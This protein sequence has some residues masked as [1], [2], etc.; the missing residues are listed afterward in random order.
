[1]ARKFFPKW[2]KRLLIIFVILIVIVQIAF[3]FMNFRMSDRKV[4]E[5]FMARSTEV[6]IQRY[7]VGEREIRYV[8][9]GADTLPMVLF[10]H[11]APGGLDA[12]KE[13]LTD[14]LLA[15]K[16]HLI[17]VDRPGYGY[18]DFGNAEP[19]IQQQA[20]LLKPILEKNKSGKPAILV[21]HSY[22][23]PIVSQMAMDSP[24]LIQ[25]L[26]LAAPAID[27][28]NEKIFWVSYPAD[29]LLIRWLLPRPFRVAND[30]KLNHVKSLQAM[31]GGWNKLKLPI[32]YIHGKKDMI[33]PF[34]NTAFAKKMMTQ[35]Q[36]EVIVD[37]KM[38]H[39]VPWSHPQYIHKAIE[40]YLSQLN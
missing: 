1:M 11:G 39:F 31:K 17:S 3:L 19:S 18:S 35:A 25:A 23:G 16:A 28:S 36:L 32:T 13:F 37:D 10:V 12:F 20:T 2:V 14:S 6:K 8:E 33:V 7:K 24:S 30:E 29:W 15:G 34:A 21:G 38:N 27:P 26:V 4:T 22:G 9:T 40:K 5:Y